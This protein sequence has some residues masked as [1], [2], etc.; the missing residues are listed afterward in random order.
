M[1][2]ILI[3][4]ASALIGTSIPRIAVGAPPLNQEMTT[5]PTNV[6]SIKAVGTL[7][8]GEWTDS[9]GPNPSSTRIT[10]NTFS[11][12]PCWEHYKIL[13]VQPAQLNEIAAY[14]VEIEITSA[15]GPQYCPQSK[16]TFRLAQISA[17]EVL[18]G[19]V[20]TIWWMVCT[21]KKEFDSALQYPD[22]R[23]S[24]AVCGS[25]VSNRVVRR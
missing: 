13:G 7:I 9:I 19:N 11:R 17:D 21:S 3:L 8:I 12:S 18:S 5:K 4:A 2:I 25:F 6:P 14:V 24:N 23:K 20:T 22:P 1:K 15:G 16:P 10:E